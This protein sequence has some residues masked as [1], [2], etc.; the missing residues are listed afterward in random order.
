MKK[1]MQNATHIE[2]FLYQHNLSLKVSGENSKNPGTQFINGT[3]DIATDDAMTNIVTV[4]YSYV[5]PT[6]VKSGSPN[7]TFNVLQNI[8]NGVTCNVVEH[9]ADKAAKV[10]IDSQIGVNEFYSNRTGTEELVSVKRNEGGFIHVVQTIAASEG[11]R[12]TFAA[13]MIITKCVRQE[14]DEERNRPERMI[15]RG[16]VFDFRNALLPVDMMLY[17]A[18]GMDHFEAFE[19]SE[20]TPVFVN[21]NGHQVSKTVTTVQKSESTGWGES[22]AQEVT[23][24]QREFVITGVKDPY[25]WDLDETITAQEYKEAL[26]NREVAV[27]EI[28]RRQDE[29]N[30][31]RAQT[32]APAATTGGANGF[33]F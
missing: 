8:I 31:S 32:Q 5:T 27:A 15:V 2:G 22:F 1:S 30:A 12:D 10:R 18:G 24:T 23:S 13:D 3:I 29:Y 11:L 7:A 33:N 14:A 17:N 21:V 20:K 28:K 25:E 6:Y 16:Y 26:Q 9:G 19:A 4:H